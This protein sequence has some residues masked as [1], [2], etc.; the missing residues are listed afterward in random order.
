[1][2]ETEVFTA[3]TEK[4][5]FFWDITPSNGLISRVSSFTQA[6]F[7]SGFFFYPDDGGNLLVRN[8]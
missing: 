1:V 2:A 3:V 5:L 4:S 8:I 6:G 7:L